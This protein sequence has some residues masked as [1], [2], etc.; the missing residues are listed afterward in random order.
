MA[1]PVNSSCSGEVHPM[2]I[3]GMDLFNEGR[4]WHAHE[5]LEEAWLEEPGEVRNLY[6]GI[7]Q[8]GVVY[9]HVTRANYRGVYKVYHRA[10]RWLDPFPDLCRGINVGRLRRDL[11]AVFAEAVRIGPDELEQFD[12]SLLKPVEYGR[13]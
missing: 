11:E 10:R 13:P 5:A 3:K 8:A 9:L 7:L 2:A 12:V 1:D 4:Y 6:R